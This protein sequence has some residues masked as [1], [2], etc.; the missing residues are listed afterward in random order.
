MGKIDRFMFDV[1]ILYLAER[2]GLKIEEIPVNWADMP[3]SKVRFWPGVSQMLRDLW[4][5]RRIHP[6]SVTLFRQK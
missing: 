4:L 6:R 1:A 2:A 5:I 3:D